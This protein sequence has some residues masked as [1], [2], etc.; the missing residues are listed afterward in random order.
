MF[1]LCTY[2]DAMRWKSA[3][4]P[5]LYPAGCSFYRTF[6]YRHEYI[7]E[8]LLNTFRGDST[9]LREFIQNGNRN[10]GIFG[11]R[12]KTEAS[13]GQFVPLRYVSLTEPPKV[14]DTVDLRFRLGDY[15]ELAPGPALNVIPLNEIIDYTKQGETTLMTEIPPAKEEL[16]TRLTGRRDIPPGLWERLVDDASLP[17]EARL[18]FSGTTIL[19]LVKVLDSSSAPELQPQALQ[20]EGVYQTKFGYRLKKNQSYSFYFAY[21]RITTK[22]AAHRPLINDFE[23][24][25]KYNA[26]RN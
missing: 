16:F 15:I 26:P 19:R 11:M 21:N 12:F 8:S 25:G 14:S 10:K 9:I 22:E 4:E 13:H 7:G 18:N 20:I 17:E 6:S 23:F 24:S 2:A 1:I 3:I 5:L